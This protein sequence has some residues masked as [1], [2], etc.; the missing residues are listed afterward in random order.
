MSRN[1][2]EAGLEYLIEGIS[3]LPNQV[4]ELIKSYPDDIKTC[5]IGYTHIFPEEK[6]RS[7]RKYSNFPNNWTT[8]YSDN[9]ILDLIKNEIEHS[10]KLKKECSKYNIAYFDQLENFNYAIDSIIYYLKS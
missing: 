5:F 6:L 4:N 2:I 8:G 9:E 7:I 10:I 3:I 1:I